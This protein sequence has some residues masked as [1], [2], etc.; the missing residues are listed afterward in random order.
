MLLKNGYPLNFIQTQIRRF[1][2]SKHQISNSKPPDKNLRRMIFKLP[3]IGNASVHLEKELQ[4]FYRRKL[5]NKV[6][7]VVFHSTFGIGNKFRYKDKQPVLHRN[8]V[9]YKLNCSCGA[10]Y[11]GQT[12]RNLIFRLQEHNPQTRTNHQTDVTSH[13]LENPSHSIKFDQPEVLATA[14]NL[15]ELLIKETWLIH[16]HNSSINSDE[17]S[18]PLHLF[19]T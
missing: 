4:S 17:S 16:E 14:N 3:Y 10:S 18:T 13:L 8:I 9:V 2:D 12:R 15:R 7:L 1:L 19:N 5:G 11:I 6:R